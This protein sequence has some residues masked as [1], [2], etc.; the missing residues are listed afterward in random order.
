MVQ[1]VSKKIHERNKQLTKDDR[2]EL[3][4]CLEREFNL[5]D[6]A[7]YLHCSISTVKREI[8]RNKTLKLNIKA[9]NKCGLKAT[10]KKHNVCGNSRCTHICKDCK[11]PKVNCND[12]CKEFTL[13]P[14]CK[15][16]KHLSGVC[17]GC[18]EYTICK[19]NKFIYS[20]VEAQMKHQSNQTNAH[21]GARI[22]EEEANVFA[23]FLK[24]LITK[25]LSLETIKSQ[26]P[27]IFIYSIQTV[28]NWIDNGV[29]PLNNLMLVRKVR[30][31][32]RKPLK[33]DERNINRAYLENRY[34]DDFL[35]YITNHP[36]RLLRYLI[37]SKI[38]LEIRFSVSISKL[39]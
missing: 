24:P 31:T 30:Y 28:Y 11:V 7:K 3:V 20:A 36:I 12:Y 32:K 37:I 13:F 17:N 6:T 39:F 25:N 38:L 15:K 35:T 34:Y 22:N 8:D 10:C 2:F 21:K 19:L 33:T 4:K 1:I 9:K 16:L 18:N 27:N 5:T 23:D 14:N 29:L 26:Y